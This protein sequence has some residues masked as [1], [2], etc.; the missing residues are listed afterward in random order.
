VFAPLANRLGIWDMRNREMEDLSFRFLEPRP[1]RSVAGL[2]DEKRAEREASV[3]S[4]CATRHGGRADR[5]GIACAT[6]QGRP[7]HIYSIV[8]ENARQVACALIGCM[9]S[10]R[11]AWWCADVP[12]CYAALSWVHSRFSAHH[13]G[14]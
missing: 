1:T 8:Q 11:C 7:K 4:V 10:G 2:L 5:Q 14:V 9:T 13:R 6:V 3:D 12:D